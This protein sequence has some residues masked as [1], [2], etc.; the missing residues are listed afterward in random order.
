MK[1]SEILFANNQKLWDEACEKDFVVQMAKGT[2]SNDRFKKYM[3]QDYL[4]LKEYIEIL[5]MIKSYSDSDELTEFI[6]SAITG[7]GNELNRVHIPNMKKIGISDNEIKAAH[8]EDVIADY[9]SYQ[10][11]CLNE[12]GLLAGLSALLQCSW[13]YAYISKKDIE[14]YGTQI[15]T[16]LYKDWFEAYTSQ[17][18]LDTNRKWIDILDKISE[19]KDPA[20]IS[21]IK[22]I[23][24]KCAEFENRFWDSL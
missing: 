4:Y 18:Y 11:S 14:N 12:M 6:N 20:E 10:K 8:M 15:S 7:T 22:E 3:V 13:V 24:I 17:S 1:L 19:N 2:L 21:R 9:V 16:S 23:F 5:K